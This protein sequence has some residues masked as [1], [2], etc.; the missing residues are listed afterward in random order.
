MNGYENVDPN[1][2]FKIK[3]GKGTR[4]ERR[5]YVRKYSFPP[6]DRK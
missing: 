6:E 5:L 1:I 3:T 4:G 2:F